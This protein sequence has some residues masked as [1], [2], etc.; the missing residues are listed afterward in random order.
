[1]SRVGNMNGSWAEILQWDFAKN[2]SGETVGDVLLKSGRRNSTEQY[3]YT[4]GWFY[5][6]VNFLKTGQQHRET[7][8]GRKK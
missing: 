4:N 1:M 5:E 8:M 7:R 3:F 6:K 2:F